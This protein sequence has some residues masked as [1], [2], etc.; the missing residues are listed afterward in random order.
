VKIALQ[1][2]PTRVSNELLDTQV[3][4]VLDQLSLTHYALP[5]R[6]AGDVKLQPGTDLIMVLGGDGTFLYGA[7]VAAKYGLPVLGV[8]VG[9]VGFLCGVALE[10][11]RP[12]LSAI[13][14]GSLPV[15]ERIT[16]HGQVIGKAEERFSQ[17][18]VNDI[19]LFRSG[20]EKIRD[21][22]ARDNG[23]LIA[24]Y[25]ADGIILASPTGS[26]AYTMAAGGPL[27]HPSLDVI[28]MTPVCAHSMFTKPLVLPSHHSI[29]ITARASSYPLTVSFDGAYLQELQP[30]DRLEV[31]RSETPLR[32]YRPEDYDFYQVLR[33]KF[34][35]GYLYGGEDV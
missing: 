27:V 32:V 23:K 31:T 7:R 29:E 20:T 2:H 28:I 13:Q 33:Q 5:R 21:Y 6:H 1:L 12:A 35:H 3:R 9:R 14:S 16:L 17:I 10:N 18:A 15:E 25:R 19:V 34:Q 30:G 11:L 4:P 22:A 8:M 24:R 26:T